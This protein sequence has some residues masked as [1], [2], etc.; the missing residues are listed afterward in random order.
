MEW[1]LEADRRLK[2][3]LERPGYLIPAGLGTEDAACSMAAINLALNGNLNDFTPPCMSAII[4]A[5]IVSVQ[6][7]IPSDIRNSREWRELLPLAA[8]TGRDHEKERA[9]IV[10]DW[11]WDDVLPLLQPLADE[12]GCG[13]AWRKMCSGRTEEAADIAYRSI[14]SSGIGLFVKIANDDASLACAHRSFDDSSRMIASVVR[15][16]VSVAC[17]LDHQN[18]STIGWAQ[19]DP[20]GLLRRLIDMDKKEE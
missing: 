16:A 3:Y 10:F 13:D 7:V 11:L 1:T 2:E 4:G 18:G 14:A 5:V 17:A 19:I 6:D 8:G 15:S 9:D 12:R 20:V